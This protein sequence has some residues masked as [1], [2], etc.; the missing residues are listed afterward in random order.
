MK[1]INLIYKTIHRDFFKSSVFTGKQD[2]ENGNT[3][4]EI[5]NAA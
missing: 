2:S 5:K 1:K 3:E 4:K